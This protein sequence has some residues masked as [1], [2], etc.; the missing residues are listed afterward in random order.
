MDLYEA[1]K[2]GK[3]KEELT[4]LFQSEL[5]LAE[6]RI[7]E[8]KIKEENEYFAAQRIADFRQDLI[9]ACL[10]Y[11]EVICDDDLDDDEEEYITTLIQEGLLLIEAEIKKNDFL[12]KIFL[13]PSFLA[14]E[15]GNISDAVLSEFLASLR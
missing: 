7:Q 4:K 1:L 15:S 3:S 11:I 10:N 2:E 8:E 12:K 6:H 13:K 14:K 9:N 5:K